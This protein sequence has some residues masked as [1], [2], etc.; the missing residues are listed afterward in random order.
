MF[1]D[2]WEILQEHKRL[3]LIGW[4]VL[5]Q[6][7]HSTLFCTPPQRRQFEGK[8]CRPWTDDHTPS[9]PP[10]MIDNFSK[11][12]TIAFQFITKCLVTSTKYSSQ[13]TDQNLTIVYTLLPRGEG[14]TNI[15]LSQAFTEYREFWTEL[16]TISML[17]R[18]RYKSSEQYTLQAAF[19]SLF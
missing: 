3:A 9:L 7:I 6:L 11:M 12:F 5:E 10:I 4:R 15:S 8:P 13:H 17:P 14:G 16:L 2:G 18:L 1:L 19:W